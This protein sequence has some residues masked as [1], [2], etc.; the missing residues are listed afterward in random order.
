MMPSTAIVWFRRD[1]R[2][3]DHPPLRAALDAHEQVIPVFVFDDRLLDGRHASG[4]R[5][6]FMLESLTDLREA[7]RQR[8]LA[9]EVQRRHAGRLVA[10]H[11]ELGLGHGAREP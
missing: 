11:V 9:G 1:L 7:L 8:P 5:T 4:S 2:V 3:H 6:R 10:L